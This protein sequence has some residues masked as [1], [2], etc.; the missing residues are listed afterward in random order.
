MPVDHIIHDYCLISFSF[1]FFLFFFLPG[2]DSP[3]PLEIVNLGE[4]VSRADLD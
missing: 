2:Q 1:L 3:H 4:H